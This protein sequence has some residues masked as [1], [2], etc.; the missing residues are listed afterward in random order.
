MVDKTGDARVDS[1]IDK[2]SATIRQLEQLAEEKAKENDKLIELIYK[3][4]A[5]RLGQ[6]SA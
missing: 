5:K 6:E 3:S 1:L 4:R 2:N